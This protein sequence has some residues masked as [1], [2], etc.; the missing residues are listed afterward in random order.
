[1]SFHRSETAALTSIY[2]GTWF[3]FDH[4]RMNDVS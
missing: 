2:S 3:V 4:T 1:M